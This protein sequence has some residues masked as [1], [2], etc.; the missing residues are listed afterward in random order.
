[1]VGQR[2]GDGYPRHATD[3]LNRL[4]HAIEEIRS[5]IYNPHLEW[6][7]YLGDGRPLILNG[8]NY[9]LVPHFWVPAVIPNLEDPALWEPGYGS[10]R[11]CLDSSLF[12]SHGEKLVDTSLVLYRDIRKFAE[13]LGWGNPGFRIE[14]LKFLAMMEWENPSSRVPASPEPDWSR[15]FPPYKDGFAERVLDA[16]SKELMPDI[17]QR[18]W[19][20]PELL[21]QL[22]E[23]LAPE[24]IE[25]ILDQAFASPNTPGHTEESQ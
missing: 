19:K 12:W 16:L 20:L 25:P 24:V 14:W 11:R 23:D 3:F 18:L 4:L 2:N 1:M 10:L 5:C 7:F 21:Q 6:D 22:N 13:E 17:Y 15:P 8:R 9:G